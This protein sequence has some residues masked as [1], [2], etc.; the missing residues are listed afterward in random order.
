MHARKSDSGMYRVSSNLFCLACPRLPC[1]QYHDSGP[2]SCFTIYW[3]LFT[4]CHACAFIG[5]ISQI[6]AGAAV[7]T[8]FIAFFYALFIGSGVFMIAPHIMA[9][10]VGSR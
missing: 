8:F 6:G 5:G 3:N 7:V 10:F 2:H 9:C 1:R 4:F